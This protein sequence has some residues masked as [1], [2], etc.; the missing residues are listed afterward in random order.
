MTAGRAGV[1]RMTKARSPDEGDRA[2]MKQLR[3]AEANID[4]DMQL[5]ANKIAVYNDFISR[6]AS[7]ALDEYLLASG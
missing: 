4:M 3:A 2:E 6:P 7:I 1:Q 5:A